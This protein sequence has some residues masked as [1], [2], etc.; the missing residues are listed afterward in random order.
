[1]AD[2]SKHTPDTI[3]RDWLPHVLLLVLLGLGLWLLAAVF[4]QVF[5]PILLAACL[6]LLTTTVVYEPID[7]WLARL[8]PG[9]QAAGRQQAAGVVAAVTLVLILLT[10]VVLLVIG[11]V[12]SVT[13]VVEMAWGIASRDAQALDALQKDIG[14]VV[15]NLA[16]KF[17][18][19]NLQERKIP[20]TVAA[21]VQEMT[22]FGPAALKFIS[23]GTSA[24]V[25][26]VLAFVTL[27][28]LYPQGPRLARALL[29][30]SPLSE[31]DITV[32]QE[33]HRRIV[34][35]LLHDTVGLA[36]VKALLLGL[37][38]WV[39]D[40]W[41]V[42]GDWAERGLLPVLPIAYLAGLLNLL[43]LVG[44]TMVW[45]PLA[46]Y[47]WGKEWYAAAVLLA[48]G[49]VAM[50]IGV[51]R[52]RHHVG[53][54]IDDRRGTW[55]SFLLFLGLIGGLLSFGP[56]G[57]V[58]GPVAVVFVVTLGSFWLPL[59]GLG[60]E[61]EDLVDASIEGPEQSDEADPCS[62]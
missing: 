3:I 62:T 36:V 40:R 30:F 39:V 13:E 18:A 32:L 37:L 33:R 34:A 44:I 56:K 41:V 2:P 35:R 1:M 57:F 22:G 42:P 60:K 46:G 61:T 50:Q 7:R 12:G 24:I 21:S 48:L 49:A 20:E 14:G 38:I 52:L 58:I 8:L 4:A 6:A 25:Q 51:A 27:A 47:Y 19:L 10:P 5:E 31:R 53:A 17:P 55:L 23:T 54:R 9:V 15:D 45:L 43:P 11:T 26:L 16:D 59:Y 29:R 28:F